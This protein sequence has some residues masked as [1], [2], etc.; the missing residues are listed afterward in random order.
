M[1]RLRARGGKGSLCPP[2]PPN[3]PNR[4][5]WTPPPTD[6][7]GAPPPPPSPSHSNLPEPPS[8]PPPPPRGLWPIVRWG[9]SWRPELRGRPPPGTGHKV[10]CKEGH[11]P[12][13]IRIKTPVSDAYKRMAP[14]CWHQALGRRHHLAH[15][16]GEG[17]WLLLWYLCMP[18]LLQLRCPPKNP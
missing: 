3:T 14:T 1:V 15:A 17:P 10:D 8:M 2:S 5:T 16:D 4:P 12:V 6:P 7:P 11:K 18:Q 13:A 9:G